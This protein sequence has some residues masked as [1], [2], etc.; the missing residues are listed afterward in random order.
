MDPQRIL[1]RLKGT[2]LHPQWLSDRFH[3]QS[4]KILKEIGQSTVIN[5]G[6]GD[7]ELPQW[8][9][10]NNFLINLDYPNTNS[11]YTKKPD[12]FGDACS[13]PVKG[14]SIDNVLLLEVVEHV[15]DERKALAEIKRVLKPQG[16]L[17]L[18]VP[19]IYPVHDAPC[20][21]RRLTIYGLRN[22]LTLYGFKIVLEKHHG[23]SFLVAMQLFNLALLEIARDRFRKN[24]NSGIMIA[25]LIY[26]LCLTVNILALPL[27]PLK[28]PNAS[29]F[30][31]FIIAQKTN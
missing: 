1:K 22:L 12:V 10:T 24:K 2:I 7:S 3:Q 29:N 4:R 16:L 21:Y 13:L 20:D 31:H 26:P 19:F 23:N 17:Y 11:K 18:S 5:L 27:V 14:E 9:I 28:H 6:S 15:P 25:S 8:L 30:G